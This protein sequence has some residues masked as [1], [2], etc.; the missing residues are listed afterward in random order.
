MKLSVKGYEENAERELEFELVKNPEGTVT[1][2]ARLKGEACVGAQ[3]ITFTT[4]APQGKVKFYRHNL[5]RNDERELGL[6]SGETPAGR[7]VLG[8]NL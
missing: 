1:V 6:W 4:S 8:E 5:E 2:F 7:R 3:L